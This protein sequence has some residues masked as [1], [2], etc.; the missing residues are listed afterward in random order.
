M[1]TLPSA[2]RL[3]K[4]KLAA[5]QPWV[6]LLE[7]TLPD[8]TV[9]RLAQNTEDVTYGAQTWTA[10]SFKMGEQGQSG[11]GKI[12]SVTIQLANTARALTPYIEAQSGLVGSH[13][14]LL[15]VHTGNLGEDYTALTLSYLVMACVVDEQWITFTLGADSP[16]RK[17]FPLYTATPLHC[18]LVRNF[19]GAECAYAGA[20][21]TCAGTLVACRAKSN[22]VRF[23]GRPGA[24]GA[25]RFV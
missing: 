3:E 11:D 22:S 5:T 15:V 6:L 18:P 24:T 16:F 2:L 8:T 9:Q 7:L 1:L 21:T 23:G 25:P 4:N 17:R 20:D 13:V 19:K 12:Q 10:F 14:R